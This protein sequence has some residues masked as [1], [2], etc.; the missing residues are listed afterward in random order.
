MCVGNHIHCVCM[1]YCIVGEFANHAVFTD[2]STIV[3]IKVRNVYDVI[4]NNSM[5]MNFKQCFIQKCFWGR[6]QI[7]TL[8]FLQGN[9]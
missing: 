7:L 3:K 1:C 6:G 9:G 8:K 4:A 2:R 5:Y